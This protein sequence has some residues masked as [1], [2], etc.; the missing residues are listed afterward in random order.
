MKKR[1]VFLILLILF[2]IGSVY[3]QRGTAR[4]ETINIRFGSVLPRN[5]DFGRT[6]DRMASEWERATNGAVRVTVSHDGREGTEQ[7]MISA[8]SS[9]SIQAGLF[10]AAGI[11]EIC[12]AIIT[13]STPFMI[14]TDNELDLILREVEP[15]LHSRVRNDFVVV[16]WA[17]GGWL[18]LF[19]KEPILTPADLRRQR[20]ASNPELR[21]MNLAFRTMGFTLA[22]AD[23]SNMG[24]RLASNAINAIYMAPTAVAPLQLHRHLNHMLNIPIA[25]VMGALVMNRV[26]WDRLTSEQQQAIVRVTQRMVVEFNESI[27]RSET[28]AIT[29]MERGGL[30]VNRPSPAQEALWRTELDNSINSL[31]GPVFDREIYQIANRIL[32]RTRSGR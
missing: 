18:Y 23:M 19:S 12:P 28:A 4:G 14:R 3:A 20:L 24:P 15:I 17:K 31:V 2:L 25:P 21:D 13:M 6:L 22:D 16:A 1:A 27:P 10:S 30:S 5:S 11:S 29:A 9:N 26:T 7:N 8:I 32:E